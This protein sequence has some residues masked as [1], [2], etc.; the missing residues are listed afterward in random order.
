MGFFSSTPSEKK[1]KNKDKFK[2]KY[3]ILTKKDYDS[4]SKGD[5]KK[6]D[7]AKENNLIVAQTK[8]GTAIGNK[9][10]V[11]VFDPVD[12]TI[13]SAFNP[14]EPTKK[15]LKRKLETKK[16][17]ELQKAKLPF[18]KKR[19]FNTDYGRAIGTKP[20]MSTQT[21]V[22]GD[23]GKSK[24]LIKFLAERN[25]KKNKGGSIDYRKGGMVLSTADN[26]KKK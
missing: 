3:S 1:Q 5:K 8:K 23:T 13:I 10:F 17:K 15:T 20:D 2:D 22:F 14:F 26:R 21:V 4:L 25:K 9:K 24:P 6:Y 11:K 18:D 16:D 7:F 12:Y 19:D